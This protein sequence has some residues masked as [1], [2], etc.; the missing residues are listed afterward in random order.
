MPPDVVP[1]GCFEP[2]PVAVAGPIPSMRSKTVGE[3]V[4][5]KEDIA[6][7]QQGALLAPERW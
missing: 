6:S 3:S 1:G 7:N 5:R 2:A 4:K